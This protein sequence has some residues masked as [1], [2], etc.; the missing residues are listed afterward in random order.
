METWQRLCASAS[1]EEGGIG[2][3]FDVEVGGQPATGFV[4]RHEGQLRAFLNRC[5]HVP[6]ELD[7][8][9]GRFFDDDGLVI[10][11]STHGAIYDAV[12]GRCAGGPCQGRGGLRPITVCERDDE[13][14]WQPDDYVR[15]PRT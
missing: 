12:D 13:V 8:Q 3:R 2:H 14:F 1:I 4:V 6:M 9:P 15:L 11:C 5:A 7:W 10:V